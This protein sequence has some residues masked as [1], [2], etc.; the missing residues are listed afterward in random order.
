[1]I[2]LVKV[3]EELEKVLPKEIECCVVEVPDE[4]KG[5][6]IVAVVS[7][8]IDEKS[9]VKQLAKVLP[10]LAMPKQFLIIEELPKMGS[11]KINFSKVQEMVIERLKL[12]G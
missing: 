5:A 11:G 9:V 6:K 7:Q 12:K 3:E 4:I 10:N 2:S 1:M 8:K